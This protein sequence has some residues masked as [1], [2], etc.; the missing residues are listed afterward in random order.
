M[1]WPK[2]FVFFLPLL[3][4]CA[5]SHAIVSQP[6]IRKHLQEGEIEK[7][8]QSISCYLPAHDHKGAQKQAF[9][10]LPSLALLETYQGDLP[11]ACGHWTASL[12]LLQDQQLSQ[13]LFQYER[14]M[15]DFYSF[16]SFAISD[17][18]DLKEKARD[19]Y[20]HA[21]SSNEAQTGG[22][23]GI[24]H[25]LYSQQELMNGNEYRAKKA[26]LSASDYLDPVFVQHEL[27]RLKAKQGDEGKLI[28]LIHKGVIAPI[29]PHYSPSSLASK[30]QVKRQLDLKLYPYDRAQ[31]DEHWSSIRYLPHPHF[32]LE[33]DR[34]C[35]D[36]ALRIDGQ[37]RSCYRA[38]DLQQMAID[39]LDRKRPEQIASSV[40]DL[41]IV[42]MRADSRFGSAGKEHTLLSDASLLL[43]NSGTNMDCHHFCT[44]PA[45]IDIASASLPTGEHTV[46]LE[47]AWD[48]Q[49][50]E[51]HMAIEK[52]SLHLLHIFLASPS[53][54]RVLSHQFQVQQENELD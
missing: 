12:E 46:V 9:W 39:E 11:Q 45:K 30:E 6:R 54:I 10:A 8:K 36:Y 52:K 24:I 50:K 7:A 32:S 33:K 21:I 28:V 19:Y 51:L 27:N 41:L 4:L 48:K 25:Y 40:A 1:R 16:F 13:K 3:L 14:S 47:T 31:V 22:E 2:Y 35:L 5:C 18:K 38:L 15:I 17:Q 44:L 43:S 34:I 42:K 37:M 29:T 23:I 20:S 26:L 49:A 53:S